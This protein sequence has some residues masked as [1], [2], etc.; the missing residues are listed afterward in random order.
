MA[1]KSRNGTV[2]YAL[3]WQARFGF[4]GSGKAWC[5]EAMHGVAGK[6][7]PG[8]AWLCAE[9]KGMA[10]GDWSVL[11]RCVKPRIC[12]ARIGRQGE[13]VLGCVSQC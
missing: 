3:V 1:G 5:R 2:P 12:M 4:A 9:G 11:E 13:P 10:G 6:A 7:R 8:N